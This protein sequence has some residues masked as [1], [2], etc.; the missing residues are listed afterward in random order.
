MSCFP[1]SHTTDHSS[2]FY[3]PTML[4]P[5]A[6]PT[7]FPPPHTT[8]PILSSKYPAYQWEAATRL[9]QQNLATWP[10]SRA[11]TERKFPLTPERC[12][13]QLGCGRCGSRPWPH[14]QWL[15][16]Q[17]K[18][19]LLTNINWTPLCAIGYIWG[20]GLQNTDGEY[21]FVGLWT[22]RPFCPPF[23][24]GKTLASL[25]FPEFQRTDS[26]SS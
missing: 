25:T 4:L 20:G 12:G 13:S 6:F 2:Q 26:K 1:V 21:S 24:V 7:P 14:L 23:L 15:Q 17:Q 18:E 5:Q 8:L 11:Y 16:Q 22:Q 10:G 19:H 9:V 3:S